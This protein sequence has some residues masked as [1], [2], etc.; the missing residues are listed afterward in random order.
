MSALQVCAASEGARETLEN[1]VSISTVGPAI[2]IVAE[3]A[4][5]VF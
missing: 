1:A 2:S 4:T 3:E 5:F